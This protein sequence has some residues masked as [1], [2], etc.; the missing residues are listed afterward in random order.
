LATNNPATQTTAVIQT[1]LSE[2][3]YY[4]YVRNSGA[5]NPQVS[6][7]SGYTAYG[8]LGQYFIN[9]YVTASSGYVAPPIAEL[10]VTDLTQADQS[11]KQF[12]VTYSDDVAIAAASLDSNDIQVT[13]PNGY[14]QF[15]QFVSVNTSGNGSPRTATYA[16]TPPGGGTWSP[17]H[18]GTYLVFMRSNQVSDTEGMPVAAGL[19]G[20]FQIAVPMAIYVANFDT[21]PGWTLEPQWQYGVPAYPS[22]GP[23]SGATG[24]KIIA[25]NL[26]GEYVNNLSVKYAT[27]PAIDTT[28]NSALTLRF[29]RW[30]RTR[31]NDTASLQVST[32]ATTWIT[33]WS[34]SSAVSDTSW[35]PMQ[36]SLPASV[37]GSS[38]LR[39]R[40][41][42]ASNQ[43]QNE[44]GWNIDD[45]QLL[46]D[47]ALDSIAPVPN[48]NVVDIT[49]GGFPNHDCQV[50]YTDGSAVRLN[51]LD[52]ADLMVTGPNGYSNQLTFVGADLPMDGSPL[53]GIYSLPAPGEQWDAHDNG[54][55]T[56]TLL[57]S[58]VEDIFGNA[59]PQ[60]TLGT[61]TVSISA[62]NPGILE[63]SPA[64]G[65][66]SSG[67]AGGPFS[68]AAKVFTLSNSGGTALGWSVG[69]AE[70]WISLSAASGT[71][72]AG[73]S[74]NITISVNASANLL[75]A[76]NYNALAVFLN[77]TSGTGNTTRPV[78]LTVT[79]PAN[80]AL[81][82]TVNDPAKGTVNLTNG[83]YAAGTT[84]ELIA[85]PAPFYRFQEWSGD[86]HS[87]NNP[88]TL[89]LETN[90][91]AQAIFTEVLTTNFSTPHAWLAAAGYTNDFET[92][93]T[94]IGANGMPL[95]Q[96]YVAGLNP[97]DSENRLLIS[98]EF[99]PTSNAF[100]L[101]WSTVTG[102]VY[103]IWS[104]PNGT[105]NFT[106]LAGATDLP[107]TINRFT[108]NFQ[109][110]PQQF[111]RLGVRKL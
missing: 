55:Y 27:T 52:G 65:L 110:A 49:Q 23:T 6:P 86:A 10:L 41:G 31:A 60:A 46:G 8:S 111:Y 94:L 45:V 1:N 25:Y 77:T 43:N 93:A 38:T 13:G 96:S 19:L 5:G 64:D 48:L 34:S 14:A 72:A 107:A 101:S 44:L 30:L 78:N 91:T 12:A 89:I 108:N 92:A 104:S 42:L 20:Q 66:T 81:N 70:N 56:I 53:T 15:A 57:E 4:L 9:G 2:G 90:T 22:A 84:V 36:Y 109:F 88:L 24:S 29:M 71:L 33:V 97:H 50:T 87:T 83:L 82:V 21:D 32:N 16:I 61:F 79:P 75:P 3:R 95:W 58:A 74:T 73:G 63:V 18:N 80:V 85:L 59:T 105:D 54:T 11:T 106:P 69:T 76:A 51:T 7:P 17:A 98:G 37:A 103:T 62:A 102:R 47:N 39:L 100:V 28:G 68:P 67:S 40:W 35:Q 26:S 99:A